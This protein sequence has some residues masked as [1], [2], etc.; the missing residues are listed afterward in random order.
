MMK[1]G[2]VRWHTFKPPDKQRP[3]VILTRDSVIDYMDRITI[4]PITTTIRDI[5][6]EV[7]LTPA[8]GVSRVSVVSLDNITTIQ[9]HLLGR[10][11]TVLPPEKMEEIENAVC[12]ALGIDR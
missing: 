2:E 7:Y 4:A 10:L 12:F 3:V 8:H 6:T 1:R 5:P 11:I 9:K